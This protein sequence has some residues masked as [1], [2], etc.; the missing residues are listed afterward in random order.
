MN[1][2]DR[3]Q[4]DGSGV[5]RYRLRPRQPVDPA[6]TAFGAPLKRAEKDGDGGGAPAP[7]SAQLLDALRGGPSCPW[8][9]NPAPLQVARIWRNASRVF[10]PGLPDRNPRKKLSPAQMNKK[11]PKRGPVKGFSDPSRL[12]LAR[13]LGTLR[14]DVETITMALTL[15]SDCSALPHEV[16]NHCFAVLG[17][18]F[19][20]K[21]AFRE[22]SVMWKR[23]LQ[24]RGALHWHL[25]IYGLGGKPQLEAQVR[26]WLVRQWNDLVC[27][28]VT[29]DEKEHHRW[30]HLEPRWDRQR[31]QWV[32]NW[33]RVRDMAG[34]FAK[35]IGKDPEADDCEPIPGRWWG[36]WNKHALPEDS[37]VEV[38]LPPEVAASFHRV[39]RKR[40][41]KKADEGKQRAVVSRLPSGQS[42]FQSAKER[43]RTGEERTL[44]Q[45]DLERL[46]MGYIRGG[47]SERIEHLANMKESDFLLHV[48][49]KQAETAGVRFGKFKFKGATSPLANMVVLGADAPDIA[50]R[51]LEW[52]YRL[53]GYESPDLQSRDEKWR[54]DEVRKNASRSRVQTALPGM[55]GE[56]KSARSIGS[57][58]MRLKRGALNA[59]YAGCEPS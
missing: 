4:G 44:S 59:A 35:Y 51:T 36:S 15:P 48:L 16:T 33:E 50:L 42:P 46:R 30:W 23:E 53:H 17:R 18:R 2:E 8:A 58:A 9:I 49:R 21:K 41:Q 5:R 39:M 45:W 29:A 1:P 14:R 24:H 25:L 3:H 43:A 57:R 11:K 19:A 26:A 6:D 34:Y 54:A 55:A 52:A 12:N 40:R 28:D 10:V 7:P 31:K 47:K 13:K 37:P 32:E 56:G 38:R 20:A 27:L 22:V